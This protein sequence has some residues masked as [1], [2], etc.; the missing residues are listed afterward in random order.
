MS[1][2][3]KCAGGGLTGNGPEPWA[4][5]G[6]V[7]TCSECSGTG[8]I[9]DPQTA[10]PVDNEHVAE[11]AAQFDEHGDTIPSEVENNFVAADISTDQATVTPVEEKPRGILSRM[12]GK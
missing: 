8:V 5:Q 9:A 11:G 6:H 2:C 7:T 4:R 10:P 12:F 1:T 3:T